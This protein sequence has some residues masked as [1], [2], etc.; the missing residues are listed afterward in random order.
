MERQQRDRAEPAGA[1][2]A[3]TASRPS[4]R[5]ISV[6]TP[7]AARSSRAAAPSHARSVSFAATCAR[8]RP[9]SG[10]GFCAALNGGF[11][12]TRSPL[13]GGSPAAANVGGRRH[14]SR[15]PRAPARRDRCA[16]R[17]RR[18]APQA[19][20]RS[21]PA[22]RVRPRYAGRQRE[23][24]RADAGA[25]IDGVIAGARRGSPPPAGWRHGRRDGRGAA[26]AA[27][28]R[29]PRTA[30][31]LVS[32]LSRPSRR[33]SWPRPASAAVV[34]RASD[35]SSPTSMRRGRMPSEPSS[36]LMFWSSTR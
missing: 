10:D 20:D 21:R 25:E 35:S 24:G 13:R 36:T 8:R 29:P 30:S 7:P 18:R 2:A 28:S 26:G 23:A 19:P 14:N 3:S 1:S 16:P 12:S 31:S 22:S 27:A 17:S 9:R 34:A 5:Q 32:A 4:A 6:S 33:S 11:I 15:Q